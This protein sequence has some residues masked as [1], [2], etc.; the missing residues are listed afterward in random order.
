[1]PSSQDK[2]RQH[3]VRCRACLYAEWNI[4]NHP[5]CEA[6]ARL[7]A[8]LVQEDIAKGYRLPNGEVRVVLLPRTQEST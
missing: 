4:P 8:L 5:R 6:G 3:V 7:F 1:M 2:Y